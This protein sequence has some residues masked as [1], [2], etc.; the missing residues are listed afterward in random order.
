MMPSDFWA[1]CDATV[2][3]L[4]PSTPTAPIKN[5]E[6]RTN[7]KRLIVFFSTHNPF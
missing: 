3:E 6:E 2:N 1:G 7:V 4:N 5:N